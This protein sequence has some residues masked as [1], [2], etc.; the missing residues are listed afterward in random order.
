[1]TDILHKYE[2]RVKHH[3]LLASIAFLVI[4]PIGVLVPRYFR[5]FTNRWW[6]A[7]WLI[8][9]F[10]AAPLVYTSLGM[11]VSA[12]HISTTPI[13]HHKRVGY[14][15]F[16][17]YSFQILLG[18]FI[19]YVRVPFLFIVH[20]PPQN[21]IH[22]ILGLTI[23][24]MAAYQVHYGLYIQWPLYVFDPP[25][26]ESAKHAWLALI[27]IFWVLYGLGLVFIPRQYRQEQEGRLLNQ[28]KEGS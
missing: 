20:R 8:N 15:I 9:F 26:K 19:H 18:L 11:A 13:D 12:N 24:A 27:I 25:V 14:A 22:A 23:L 6:W 17:L 3:A 16:S 10:I 28:D 7:H 2:Q 5:T 4:I 21:Y 1:M